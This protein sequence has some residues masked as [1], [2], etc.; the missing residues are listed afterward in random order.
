MGAAGG[1]EPPPLNFSLSENVLLIEKFFLQKYKMA[2]WK[3]RILGE[4]GEA[5][6]KFGAPAIASVGNL[7]LSVK[8]CDFESQ[9]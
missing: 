1:I 7:Q 6:L 5:I 8:N 9:G 2:G 3:S 4:L